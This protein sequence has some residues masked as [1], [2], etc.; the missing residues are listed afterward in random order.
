MLETRL[1]R[2]IFILLFVVA[3]LNFLG[4][5][6]YLYWTLWGFDT[7]VHFLAGASVSMAV[8]LFWEYYFPNKTP[9]LIKTIFLAVLVAFIIGILWE[10][11]ELYFDLTSF[12]DGIVYVRDTLS[13][14][15]MDIT[16]GFFGTLWAMKI[17]SKK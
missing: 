7:V 1:F 14:L 9:S 13:D 6:F 17:L 4:T 8:V 11:Y 15:L 12:S 10:I 5:T 16:G 2:H 3:I